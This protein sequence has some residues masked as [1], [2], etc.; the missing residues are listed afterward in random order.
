MEASSAL[1][2]VVRVEM[3]GGCAA[4]MENLQH[5]VELTVRM[6]P[7]RGWDQSEAGLAPTIGVEPS[8]RE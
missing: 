8:G 7:F 2:G 1:A 4:G 5:G 3:A 6:V